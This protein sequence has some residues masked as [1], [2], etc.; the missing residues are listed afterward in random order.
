MAL[1]KPNAVLSGQ[2]RSCGKKGTQVSM[3]L[4]VSSPH[5]NATTNRL[6]F[7]ATK[8]PGWDSRSKD[9]LGHLGDSGHLIDWAQLVIDST[10][11]IGFGGEV[12]S[13]GTVQWGRMS[14]GAGAPRALGE[15]LKLTLAAY[16]FDINEHSPRCVVHCTVLDGFG[17]EDLKFG[18][19]I[20]FGALGVVDSVNVPGE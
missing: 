4:L 6:T 11:T 3:I 1:G 5:Y 17:L 19:E 8:I 12:V 18:S 14:L 9:E 10:E 20:L 7:A 13:A 2:C 15:C 16:S